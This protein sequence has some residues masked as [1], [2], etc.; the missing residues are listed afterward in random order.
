MCLAGIGRLPDTIEDR[1]III[2][3]RRR[4]RTEEVQRWRMAAGAAEPLRHPWRTWAAEHIE[5]LRAGVDP[6]RIDP[7]QSR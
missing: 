7:G 6:E 4:K 3:L 1:S 2:T 5:T